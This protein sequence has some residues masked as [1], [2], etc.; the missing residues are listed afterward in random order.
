MRRRGILAAALLGCALGVE[1]VAAQEPVDGVCN[2]IKRN[3][4]AAGTAN[5]A[6]P[7]DA[8]T[9]AWRCDGVHGVANSQRCVNV[10]DSAGTPGHAEATW[11]TP[12]GRP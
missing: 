8:T 3:G 5:V 7:N 4:R 12:P 2:E 11:G 1:P 10:T 6:F 9:Y